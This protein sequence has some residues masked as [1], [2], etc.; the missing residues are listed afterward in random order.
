MPSLR[1]SNRGFEARASVLAGAALALALH[2]ALPDPGRAQPTPT[3]PPGVVKLR[4]KAARLP[5]VDGASARDRLVAAALDLPLGNST[6]DH[7]DPLH[8]FIVE[9]TEAAPPSPARADPRTPAPTSAD[10]PPPGGAV[11]VTEPLVVGPGPHLL[12]DDFLIQSAR[13]L[14]RATQ[15]PAK[16]E[17]PAIPTYPGQLGSVSGP[18]IVYDAELGL[19][20]MWHWAPRSKAIVGTRVIYRESADGLRWGP[21]RALFEFDGYGN[22]VL[23]SGPRSSDPARRFK[24][25]FFVLDPKQRPGMYLAFSADGLRWNVHDGPPVFTDLRDEASWGDPRRAQAVSDILDPFWDP[26]RSRY[27]A[28]LKTFPTSF[29]E[30]GLQSRTMPK[31]DGTRLTSQSW[32]NDFLHWEPP[33]RV[34]V[35]LERDEGVVE[36]YGA[37][38]LAR[39]DL[40][41]AFLRILRD[42]LPA[43]PGGPVEGIGYT[44]LA[45]SRDGRTW[46]RHDDVV[47]DRSPIPGAYDHAVAWVYGVAEHQGRVYL[48]YSAYRDGHKVGPRSI[49]MAILP[50]DR[51]VA[52]AASGAQEGELLTRPLRVRDGPIAGLWLNADAS[53]GSIGLQVRDLEGRPV[54]GLAFQDCRPVTGDGLALEVRC[55]RDFRELRDSA[56]RLEFSLRNAKLFAFSFSEPRDGGGASCPPGQQASPGASGPCADQPWQDTA[57]R[58]VSSVRWQ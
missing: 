56:F 27:G 39:G 34:F 57:P 6:Y 44:V 3:P 46:Q 43:D 25:A 58:Q 36:F 55:A 24:L 38:V 4:E 45:T 1:P 13:G 33:W 26:I 50:R 9:W 53:G 48:A 2:T 14:A 16:A 54:P 28:F 21:G 30:F 17:Q 35:P 18:S 11:S 5:D 8:R 19:F 41:I 20:R 15:P 32:S 23:D 42:D 40:L 37:T 29:L 31:G 22:A 49:G 51:F 12:I 52:R 47:L 10:N 7:R